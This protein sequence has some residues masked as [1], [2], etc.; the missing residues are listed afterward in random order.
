MP[1]TT[2]ETVTAMQDATANPTTVLAQGQGPTGVGTGAGETL[3]VHVNLVY[4]AENG[5][6]TFDPAKLL[7]GITSIPSVGS[8][9]SQ[10][11]DTRAYSISGGNDNPQF[12]NEYTFVLTT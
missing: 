4:S 8:V 5:N 10:K 9:Y 11:G 1:L 2:G 6:I 12:R 7:T 3:I